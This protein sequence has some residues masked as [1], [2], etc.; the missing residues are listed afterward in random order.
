MLGKLQSGL[1]NLRCLRLNTSSDEDGMVFSKGNE[2][3]DDDDD[4]NSADAAIWNHFNNDD[5][6]DDDASLYSGHD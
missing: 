1:P 4:Q 6:M 3:D 2:T 5:A